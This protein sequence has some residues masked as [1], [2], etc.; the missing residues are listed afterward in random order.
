MK[1]KALLA[2]ALFFIAT[3]ACQAADH[4]IDQYQSKCIAADSTTAGMTNCT[5]GASARW[6]KALNSVYAN[7]LSSI[8]RSE[9][10]ALRAAQRQWILY[11]N[12]EFKL[13]DEM[14]KTKDG[15]MYIP[16]RAADRLEIIKTRA[17]QLQAY[18][19]LQGL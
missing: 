5:N 2:A 8:S 14:Y 15:T 17:L 16:M 10:Q 19:D 7:L 4:P 11:R 1:S 9:Q 3:Q 13:I 12:A 18:R 6:G